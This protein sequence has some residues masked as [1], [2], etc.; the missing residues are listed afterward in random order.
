LR[1]QGL[2]T[3]IEQQNRICHR[4][5][6]KHQKESKL[7]KKHELTVAQSPLE[8]RL[9][10]LIPKSYSSW[11]ISKF[12]TNPLYCQFKDTIAPAQPWAV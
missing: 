8:I 1:K 2:R 9:K 3:G 5:G 11:A 12:F 7:L 6:G 10:L 4:L